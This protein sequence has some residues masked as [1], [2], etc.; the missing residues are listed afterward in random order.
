LSLTRPLRGARGRRELFVSKPT[1]DRAFRDVRSYR[2]LTMRPPSHDYLVTLDWIHGA[3]NLC[4]V[5]PARTGK[6]HYAESVVGCIQHLGEQVRERRAGLD[7]ASGLS[8]LAHENR[9][10]LDLA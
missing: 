1:A 2:G 9:R 3:D 4:P 6:S 7:V 10:R 8:T 5:G